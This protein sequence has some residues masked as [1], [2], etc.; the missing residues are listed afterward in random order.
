MN[1]RWNI[2]W[3]L[4]FVSACASS[5]ATRSVSERVD[6]DIVEIFPV[7]GRRWTYEAENEVIIALDRL[8]A[9]KDALA[10]IEAKIEAAKASRERAVERG[11]GVELFEAKLDWLDSEKDKA[12]AEIAAREVGVLCAK[13]NLELTKARLAIR[14]D[15]PVEED[16]LPPF[17]SQYE[18][19]AKELE[20]ASV[21][22]QTLTTKALQVK[23][24]WHDARGA[25]VRKT[26]DFNYG[27]WVE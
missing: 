7:E 3:M 19:C 6:S 9:A 8:D 18:E 20:D 13:T 1:A 16:F 5:A 2:V 4:G 25:Y 14:F 10:E 11:K 17:E 22:A 21:K 27:L 26:K 24:Q 12:E 15:L 23:M